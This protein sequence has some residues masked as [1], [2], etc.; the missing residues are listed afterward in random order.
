[1]NKTNE[2]LTKSVFRAMTEAKIRVCASVNCQ[3]VYSSLEL[4]LKDFT[5]EVDSA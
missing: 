1:M 5:H 4:I 3:A 2:E